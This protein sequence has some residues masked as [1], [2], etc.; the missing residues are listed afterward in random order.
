[1][2]RN[3]KTSTKVATIASKLL[4]NPK[5]SKDIRCVAASALTLTQNKKS[6]KTQK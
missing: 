3:E 2:P 1:M 4:K 6:R 5:S